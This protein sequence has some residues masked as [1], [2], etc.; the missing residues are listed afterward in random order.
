MS[1]ELGD[2]QT[3]PS[4]VMAVLTSLSTGGKRWS[5]VLEPTCGRGNFID[6]L[7]KLPEPPRE[8][9]AFEIQEVHLQVARR[10]AEQA[11]STRVVVRQANIFDLK[12]HKDVQWRE[13]GPL[14]VVGNPPWVTNAELGM[15][16]SDNLPRKANIK[17]LRGIDARTGESN[18]D[19][20][21]SIWL[22]LMQELAPEQPTI[23]L[24]CKTSVARNILQFAFDARLPVTHAAIRI[25]DA[26]KWFGIAA[27]ACLFI[28]KI[29]PGE[30]RYEAEVYPN[31][32]AIE[33]DYLTG[34]VE[35]R[36]V[37]NVGMYHQ[38][39]AI[40]GMCPI[41]W[42]QGLKHDAASV[43]ELTLNTSRKFSNKLG[44]MVVIEPEYVYPLLK[45]TDVF[46]GKTNDL[47]RAVIVTQQ[48]L[49][50]DT[51]K[52]QYAA[53]QLWHYLTSHAAVFSQRKSSIYEKQPLFALFGIGDYSFAP[54]KVGIS[55]FHKT[56]K[57]RAIGPQDGKPVMLDDTC[58]FIPCPSAL[59]AAFFASLLNDPLC[60]AFIDSIIFTD[61]KRPITKKLLQRIDLSALF[62]RSEKPALIAR[63]RQELEKLGVDTAEENIVLPSLETVLMHCA[64]HINRANPFEDE[65]GAIKQLSWIN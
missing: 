38:T 16:E 29:G 55:G 64:Q 44:E 8:I 5:R 7:L 57:F 9:Q 15:L 28:V 63:M 30:R 18:F 34:M 48:R 21:E 60:L 13:N 19:I 11:Q 49:G 54:Y 36:F 4:L 10:I 22:K 62:K 2:F 42:R 32:H 47:K 3:P 61:A 33:P 46:K 51:C 12:L 35:K 17:G 58:Y 59:E 23:A 40:D 41:P 52:L 53:P 6:G 1:K 65:A 45:S 39:A 24:L 27:D 43:M 26:H 50:E 25:I 20:A 31:L 37:A 14:L 56:P